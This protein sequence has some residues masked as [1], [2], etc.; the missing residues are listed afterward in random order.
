MKQRLAITAMVLLGALALGLVASKV[1]PARTHQPFASHEAMAAARERGDIDR[2]YAG[3]PERAKKR[4]AQ[5]VGENA[6]SADPEVRDQVG[7]ARLRIGFLAAKQGDFAL[8]RQTFLE[9]SEAHKDSQANSPE[10]GGLSDQAAYQAAVCLVAEGRKEQAT[11]EFLAFMRERPLSPLVH[12]CAMRIQRLDEP[13]AVKQAES[14]LQ[15]ATTK[16]EERIRFESSVCGPKAIAYLLDRNLVRTKSAPPGYEAIAKLCGTTD[17]GTT[18]AGMTKGLQA[19]GFEA[20]GAQLNRR[21]LS[22]IALPA[23]LLDGDH[24]MV[25][26][27]VD[28]THLLVFDPVYNSKRRL[29]LPTKD[30]QAQLWTLLTFSK[31][32]LNRS[33]T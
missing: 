5:F 14:L 7:A 28:S 19:L 12:A 10:F 15:Q 20:F 1:T 32:S 33:R 21:D 23:I 26:L 16:Q 9:A 31:P 30:V 4:Y 22:R 6:A 11:Q 24:Y 17:Q 3:K 27:E 8:A 29:K 25:L 2:L 18:M 13:A